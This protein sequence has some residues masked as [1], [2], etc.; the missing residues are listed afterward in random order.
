MVGCLFAAMFVRLYY[1][2]VLDSGRLAAAATANQ[3]RQV[4]EQA[5]RGPILDRT[6]NLIVD[7]K[8]VV[9]VTVARSVVP[10]AS[11]GAK[12]PSRY[13]PVIDRLAKVLGMTAGSILQ[14]LG[15]CRY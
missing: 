9:A 10:G 15:D 14:T 8:T 12:L 2:Q 5:P 6:G 7:N 13:P 3:V 11:C 4:T 1:L